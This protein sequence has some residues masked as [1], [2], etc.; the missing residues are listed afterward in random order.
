MS[1]EGRYREWMPGDFN[2]EVG[3]ILGG[4]VTL[5]RG[6]GSGGF[7]ELVASGVDV[8]LEMMSDGQMW[9]N[10]QAPNAIGSFTMFATAT[11]RKLSINAAEGHD[12]VKKTPIPE[13]ES[14]AMSAYRKKP[15]VI[16]AEQLPRAP[17]KWEP[18]EAVPDWKD[19][20]DRFGREVVPIGN[21]IDGTFECIGFNIKTLE[22]TMFAS[23]GDWIIRGVK[24]ELYPC[25]PDIFAA[26]YEPA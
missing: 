24:G 12:T 4:A 25:K 16:E 23:P 21:N 17:R 18:G 22:G 1:D 26:T 2:A 3:D 15:V 5:R 6:D 9:I 13:S 19:I 14:E 11:K 8:H 20:A 10:I 7:D